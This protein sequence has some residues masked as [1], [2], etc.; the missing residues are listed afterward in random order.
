MGK[1]PWVFAGSSQAPLSTL[2]AMFS[3]LPTSYG[4][5]VLAF[6]A[7]SVVMASTRVSC[8]AAGQATP[9]SVGRDDGDDDAAAGAT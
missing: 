1:K 9:A 5:T 6:S 3:H 7:C 2:S 4:F 8:A